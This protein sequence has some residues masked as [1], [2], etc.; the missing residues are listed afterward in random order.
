MPIVS[1]SLDDNLLRELDEIQSDLG[2][3]GRSEA[4]RSALRMLSADLK[5]KQDLSGQLNCVGLVTHN[6]ETEDVVTE[7]K[8]R[9]NRIIQTHIHSKLGSERCLEILVLKGDAREVRELVRVFQT[10]KRID[11]VRLV[12]PR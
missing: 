3:K 1:F 2:F 5:E 8:H 12:L 7:V 6:E 11:Q 10:S 4:I 9:F